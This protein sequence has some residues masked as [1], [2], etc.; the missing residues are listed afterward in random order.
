MNE[1]PLRE[2]DEL[3]PTSC[4]GCGLC[5]L[6]VG[7]PVLLYQTRAD[8]EQHHP[9]RPEGLPVG[10]IAEIDA[11]FRGLFRGQEPQDQCLWFDPET[12]SCKH[13]EWRP[14]VCRDYEFADHECVELRRPFVALHE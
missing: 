14:K 4:G 13:Y 9:H 6:G 5:C 1:P 3:K 12:H 10:L 8:W 7:S 2:F 11:H